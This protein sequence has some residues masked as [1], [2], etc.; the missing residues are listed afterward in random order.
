[1]RFSPRAAA[2]A[3]LLRPSESPDVTI[4]SRQPVGQQARLACRPLGVWISDRR[5]TEPPRGVDAVMLSCA[6]RNVHSRRPRRRCAASRNNG[7]A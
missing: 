6:P 5:S 2:G 1:L 7:S 4:A 3:L